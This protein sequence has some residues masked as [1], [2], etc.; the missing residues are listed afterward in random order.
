MYNLSKRGHRISS[1]QLHNS[2]GK[3]IVPRS[4]NIFRQFDY[5][6]RRDMILEKTGT[7]GEVHYNQPL[8]NKST[9][10][11]MCLADD[12]GEDHSDHF[13]LFIVSLVGAR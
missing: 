12:R 1:N 10:Y 8:R 2:L 6:L 11:P 13:S 9:G 4:K 5:I 7:S 3:K